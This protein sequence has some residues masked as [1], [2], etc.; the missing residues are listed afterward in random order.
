MADTLWLT[1]NEFEE[2]GDS[3]TKL[4]DLAKEMLDK[5]VVGLLPVHIS[6]VSRTSAQ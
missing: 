2:E 1:T 3:H 4:C 6:I 5:D